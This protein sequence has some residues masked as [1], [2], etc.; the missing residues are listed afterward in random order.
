MGKD[1]DSSDQIK[2]KKVGIGARELQPEPNL[3][4]ISTQSGLVDERNPFLF[5]VETVVETVCW[6]LQGF[7]GAG[8]R[9]RDL[10]RR[11]G[12]SFLNAIG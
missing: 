5:H 11:G 1:V 12:D 3:P 7:G 6:Y 8:F 10:G 9:P 4:E 2:G